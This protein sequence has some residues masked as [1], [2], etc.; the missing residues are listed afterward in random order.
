MAQNIQK[1]LFKEA[2]LVMSLYLISSATQQ[3][4]KTICTLML[5]SKQT[6][7]LK[8]IFYRMINYYIIFHIYVIS[9]DDYAYKFL[10]DG[11]YIEL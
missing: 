2:D 7:T 1:K 8:M 11:M 5:L 9:K 10:T 3:N 4:S 6:S